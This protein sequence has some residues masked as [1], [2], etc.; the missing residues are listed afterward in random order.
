MG[1]ATELNR[2]RLEQLLSGEV[3]VYLICFVISA[4]HFAFA[5]RRADLYHG[6]YPIVYGENGSE[7]H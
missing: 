1:G 3:I 7:R 4:S 6:I 5:L 2:R